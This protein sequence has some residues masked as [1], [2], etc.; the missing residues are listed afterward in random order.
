MT[1]E[2]SLELHRRAVDAP[3]RVPSLLIV[4]IGSRIRVAPRSRASWTHRDR[5][6]L[7]RTRRELAVRRPFGA[8]RLHRHRPDVVS[9]R[10]AGLRVARS[11]VLRPTLVTRGPVAHW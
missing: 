11:R 3:T 2:R 7:R 4:E 1:S 10:V 9:R 6:E 5:R 8:R